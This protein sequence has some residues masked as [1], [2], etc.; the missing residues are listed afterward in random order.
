MACARH[1]R[2]VSECD[3]RRD[4]VSFIPGFFFHPF[5]TL[6]R[7]PSIVSRAAIGHNRYLVDRARRR[8]PD[9]HTV[10]AET[11]Q[12]LE[13]LQ[14]ENIHGGADRRQLHSDEK[15]SQNILVPAPDT[16]GS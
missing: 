12:D 5:L 16:G 3:I 1:K 13:E 2:I 11:T 15:R 6:E 8:Y 9:A 10:L 14:V 7:F 4:A